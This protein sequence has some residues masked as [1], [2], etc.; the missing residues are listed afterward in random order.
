ML[1][2]QGLVI[3]FMFGVLMTMTIGGM[4]LMYAEWKLERAQKAMDKEI[5]KKL[6]GGDDNDGGL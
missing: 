2:W 5:L 4:A 3:M 6:F 1:S